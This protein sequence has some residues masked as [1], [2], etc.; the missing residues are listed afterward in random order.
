MCRF[1][2][3]VFRE[4]VG[5]SFNRHEFPNLLWVAGI[6]TFTLK[7]ANLIVAYVAVEN[8]SPSAFWND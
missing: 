4:T 8:K 3:I 2:T 5:P 7:V 1:S 6:C